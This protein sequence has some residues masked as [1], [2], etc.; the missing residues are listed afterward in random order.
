MKNRNLLIPF[1]LI[2]II[3]TVAIFLLSTDDLISVE[4]KQ[5]TAL[6]NTLQINFG[7]VDL[8]AKVEKTLFIQNTGENP[9]IIYDIEI[10][11]G[12]TLVEWVK[13][14]ILAGRT[15]EIQIVY[16]D[17]FPGSFI[18]TITVYANIPEILTCK[19]IGSVVE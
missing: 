14:P 10:S 5:T 12:C 17:K 18:K 8:N 19:I 13:K 15:A 4:Q 6:L 16:Q 9:L 11:C 2:A 7:D 1:L 3:S